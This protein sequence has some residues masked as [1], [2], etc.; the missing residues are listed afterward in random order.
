MNAVLRGAEAILI[1]A[2]IFGKQILIKKRVPKSYRVPHLDRMLRKTRSRI[3]ARILLAAKRVTNVP[4]VYY[5]GGDELWIEKLEGKLMKDIKIKNEDYAI[6]GQILAKLHTV[7]IVH[8]D[9]TP[10]NIM[11]GKKIWI[12]DFGLATFSR[13]VEDQAIDLLLMERAV[14]DKFQN[15]LDGYKENKNWRTVMNR[16]N[17]IKRRGRYFVRGKCA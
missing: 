7:G 14:G 16:M 11:F 17:E 2:K 4:K 6:V 3:E 13:N 1:P 8:G 12:I 10:A 15:F 9:F 5:V